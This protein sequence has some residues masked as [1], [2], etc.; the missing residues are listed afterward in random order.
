MVDLDRLQDDTMDVARHIAQM[1][2][3]IASQ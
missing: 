2:E 3:R 1:K